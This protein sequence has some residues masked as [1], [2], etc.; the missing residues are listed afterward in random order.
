MDSKIVDINTLL[1]EIFN[2][3]LKIEQ[4]AIT[5]GQF[6]DVTINEVHTVE[7]I[8]LTEEKKMSDVSKKLNIT[9]GTLTIAVNNLVEKGY[10]ERIKY[11]SDKRIVLLKLTKKGRMLYR[12]H[13]NF[14]HKMVQATIDDLTQEEENVLTTG[15]IKLHSFLVGL[16]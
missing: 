6:N 13:E 10:V 5:E 15:L 4:K 11:P 3:V 8:G 9:L 16:A 7:Q 12:V 1:V 2:D 14:H